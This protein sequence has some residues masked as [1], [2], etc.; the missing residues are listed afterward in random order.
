MEWNGICFNTASVDV[1]PQHTSILERNR[2]EQEMLKFL[3]PLRAFAHSLT[4]N[5]ANADDLVQD[6]MVKALSNFD[7]F[8]VGS[9]M[10]A[11]LFTI[12]RNT[13]CSNQRKHRREVLYGDD[14]SIAQLAVRPSQEGI[15]EMHELG[16]VLRSLPKNQ[17]QALRLVVLSG[18]SYEQAAEISGCALGTMKSRVNRA[19]GRLQEAM[20][21]E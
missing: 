18:L 19:R 17:N 5:S 16:A 14:D 7:R 11:W 1:S 10:S 2:L 21:V 4:R 3:R 6:T 12:M 15:V 8:T 20:A 13:F 9:N